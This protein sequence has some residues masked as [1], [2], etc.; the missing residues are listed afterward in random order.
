MVS[1]SIIYRSKHQQIA[2]H[3]VWQLSRCFIPKSFTIWQLPPQL[4]WPQTQ[5]LKLKPILLLFLP[6]FSSFFLLLASVFQAESLPILVT[7]TIQV[8]A[9]L[10]FPVPLYVFSSLL[11]IIFI[12]QLLLIVSI[13]QPL[14]FVSIWLLLL[15]VSI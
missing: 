4:F 2:N 11:L 13:W 15:I 10:F 5:L 14:R 3:T 1:E 6:K 9:V 12:W 8:V 7:F